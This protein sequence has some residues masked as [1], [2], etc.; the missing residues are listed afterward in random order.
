MKALLIAATSVG[1]GIAGVILYFR[2]SK[3]ATPKNGFHPIETTIAGQE[4]NMAHSMG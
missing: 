1:A 2:K 3:K 4:R